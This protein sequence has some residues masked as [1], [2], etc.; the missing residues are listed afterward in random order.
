M[1]RIYVKKNEDRRLRIGHPWIFSNEIERYE[2]NIEDGDLVDVHSHGGSFLGRGY[3]NRKSLI[4]VRM[5][6][7]V[8]EEI[9]VAFFVE[10]IKRALDGRALFAFERD[11]LRLVFSEGDFLPGLIVDRYMDCLAVQT[12]TLGMERRLDLILDAV[13][14]LLN[15][16]AVVLRNDTSVRVQEGLLPEKRVARGICEEPILLRDMSLITVVDLLNGHKTGLYLDQSENRSVLEGVVASKRVL[17]CFCYSGAWGIDAA[18]LGAAEVV[19]VES[20]PKA[21]DT[22]RQCAWLNG[23]SE[24]CSFVQEDCFSYIPRLGLSGERFDVVIVDP[25]GLVKSRSNMRAGL[26]LYERINVEAMNLLGPGGVLVTCSCSHNVDRETFLSL[27]ARSAKNAR[28]EAQ[29]VEVRSQGRDHPV[30][31]P[32]RVNEYLK[33]VVL[34]IW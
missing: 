18:R 11:A 29:I 13:E 17:D 7:R 14:E 10:R 30:L 9:N 3:I 6:T 16:T 20:S 31:L 5:L 2:G 4:S 27:L 21:L 28:R 12:T 34:K 1:P 33:C 15:P 26:E 19:L 25:P 8:P 32:G 22:A 24:K 23:V